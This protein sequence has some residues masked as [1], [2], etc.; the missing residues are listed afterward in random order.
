VCCTSTIVGQSVV[1]WLVRGKVRLERLLP[2]T[3]VAAD[4]DGFLVSDLSLMV[5]VFLRCVSSLQYSSSDASAGD[6]G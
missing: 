3:F 5:D 6:L 4:D 1:S 2:V